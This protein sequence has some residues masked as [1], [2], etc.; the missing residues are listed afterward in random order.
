M[1]KLWNLSTIFVCDDIASMDRRGSNSL[2]AIT[3]VA[4]AKAEVDSTVQEAK[5]L[6][7]PEAKDLWTDTYFYFKGNESRVYA[8]REHEE[9]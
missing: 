2:P 3:G 8:F 1:A 6:P 7:D 5:A 4:H 9:V